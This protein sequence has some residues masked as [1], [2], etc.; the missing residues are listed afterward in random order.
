MGN[1]NSVIHWTSIIRKK[2]QDPQ[3]YD[4]VNMFMS[5][6]YEIIYF[7]S[8]PRIF[9]EIH[10]MLQLSQD[11]RTCDWFLSENHTVIKVY[12]SELQP[13]LLPKFLTLRVFSLE[14]IRQ[15]LNYDHVNF[16]ANKKKT[17]FKLKKEVGP[18]IVKDK[19]TLQEVE[20]RL[21][22]MGLELTKL[23]IMILMV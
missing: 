13:Y 15:H 12:G 5:Q 3:F 22:E 7:Q 19:S 23:G 1:P 10:R 9:P 17:S 14:F 6:A 16:L 4:F 8:P 20:E 2:V 21:K 18:F 11:K